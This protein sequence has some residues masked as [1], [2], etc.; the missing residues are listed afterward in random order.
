MSQYILKNISKNYK[1]HIEPV[2]VLKDINMTISKGQTLAIIG[3]S[4]TGKSTLLH[5]LG[6]LDTPSSGT[7]LFEGQDL[8]R[9]NQKEK[10]SFRNKKLG[11]V[12]QFHNLLPEFSAIENVAMQALIAGTPKNKAL[13]LAQEML[14]LVGLETKFN[15]KVSMLSGGERQRIAIARAI[16]LEPEVLLADE[17][18]GNLDEKTGDAII[19]L[20]TTLNIKLNMTLII[21]THNNAITRAMGHCFELKSGDLYEK[22]FSQNTCSANV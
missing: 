17:P 16:L 20:L 10:A 14:E 4:G 11:F 13:T 1:S 3:A 19:H 22:T 21:V 5:I 15:Y 12:F 8:I 2:P 6:A 18:T 9:M 7:V